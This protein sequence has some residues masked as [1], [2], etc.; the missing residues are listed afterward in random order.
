MMKRLSILSA[1]LSAGAIGLAGPAAAHVD[2][3]AHGAFA[4]G[5]LHPLAGAGAALALAG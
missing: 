4:S 3:L 2:P 1:A 5:L